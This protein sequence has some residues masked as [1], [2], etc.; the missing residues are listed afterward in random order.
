MKQRLEQRLSRSRVQQD[1]L[2]KGPF[3]IV[4]IV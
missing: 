4:V 3:P 2:V 1:S